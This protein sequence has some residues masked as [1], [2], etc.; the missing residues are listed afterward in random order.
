MA[1]RVT[2][3]S[4]CFWDLD[5]LHIRTLLRTHHIAWE[6]LSGIGIAEEEDHLTLLVCYR[7][8]VPTWKRSVYRL[9]EG[10]SQLRLLALTLP[11]NDPT[12][13]QQVHLFQEQH[14][15][16]W[17][18]QAPSMVMKRKLGCPISEWEFTSSGIPVVA[19]AAV[20]ALLLAT[21]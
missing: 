20:F 18:G 5:F 19:A 17:F 1:F 13:W 11:N 9:Q 3:S 12:I 2:S 14:P 16:Y 6:S 8:P 15:H 4:R 10:S 21:Q 7:T